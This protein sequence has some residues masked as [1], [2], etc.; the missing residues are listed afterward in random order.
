MAGRLPRRRTDIG[1]QAPEG[2]EVMSKKHHGSGLDAFLEAEGVYEEMQTLAAEE[3]AIWRLT[4]A[5]PR[6]APVLRIGV[7][8]ELAAIP[9]A[10]A[11]PKP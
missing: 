10:D 2:A 4:R 9:S 1:A 7:T 6:D 11:N 8:I 5:M 3:A